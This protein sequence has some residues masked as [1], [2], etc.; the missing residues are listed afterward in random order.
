MAYPGADLHDAKFI[1]HNYV[2]NHAK[3]LKFFILELAPDM[4][5]RT[6][7]YHWIPTY[8]NNPGFPYDE[9]H[10]F[11]K[12]G[13][14][15]GFVDAVE[16]A[17]RIEDRS[18]FVYD[19]E[20]QLPPKSWGPADI[21]MDSVLFINSKDI[22][23]P[24]LTIYKGLVDAALELGV[25]VIAVV[26]PRHPGYKKTGTYGACGPSRTIAKEVID[27]VSHMNVVVLDENKW[28]DHDYSDSMAF[29]YDYLSYLGAEQVSHRLDSL[30]KT[31]K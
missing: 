21:L 15:E 1:I 8:E 18:R 20:Y 22:I 3:K 6:V 9:K 16:S 17:P 4:F 13:V 24:G 7:D 31:L 12:D 25:S 10:N 30:I 23:Y 19:Q 11:W 14:P 27:S 2:F 26:L 5:F 28:G 29:D